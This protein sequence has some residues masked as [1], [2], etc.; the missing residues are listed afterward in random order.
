MTSK[1]GSGN[2]A[3]RV[4]G[5][6][7]ES[8]TIVFPL[9]RRD[10]FDRAG[11][12]DEQ[13][14]RNQDDEMN[15]RI[16]LAGGRLW[17]TPSVRSSYDVR[18]SLKGLWKQYEQYGRFR[19]ETIAKHRRPGAP[20][21]LAPAAL[22]AGLGGAVGLEA[23]T[24]GRVPIGRVLIVGYTFALAA[25]GATEAARAGE[26]ALAPRVAAALGAMHLGSGI[27]FWRRALER[28]RGANR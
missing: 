10:V 22:V 23:L 24:R 15:H 20:R 13:L 3:F 2:A 16:R 21:Q 7:G 26:P 9:Y 4:G 12:Y 14:A 18:G 1:L 17:F 6:E 19:V 25:G 8:D 11:R 5:R 27:G 28:A